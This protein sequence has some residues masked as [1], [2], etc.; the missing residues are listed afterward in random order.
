[1]TQDLSEDSWSDL[2]VIDPHEQLRHDLD[3]LVHL[4][5]KLNNL[6]FWAAQ[7]RHSSDEEYMK[8]L[9]MQIEVLEQ[10]IRDTEPL[11]R[12][13]LQFPDTIERIESD[14]NALYHSIF[15]EGVIQ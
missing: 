12:H 9:R 6:E 1:M 3:E 5:E 2:S 11:T 15:A 10:K 7:D 13:D 4:Q 8:L 14:F